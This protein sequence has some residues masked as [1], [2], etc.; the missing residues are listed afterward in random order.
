MYLEKI[1]KL[2]PVPKDPVYTGDPA[3]IKKLEDTLN[4]KLPT[5]YYE[6]TKTYG[7]GYFGGHFIVYNPFIEYE[8]LNL[9]F[10]LK[11][12]R[13]CYECA[14]KSWNM[15]LPG[16]DI[17]GADALLALYEA[18]RNENGKFYSCG[19]EFD[20]IGHP[21]SFFPE[22][23]GLFPCCEYN[24][25]YTIYW[26]TGEE[27]WTIVVYSNDCYSEFDMSLTEFIYKLISK[28]V[29]LPTL[30][31]IFTLKGLMFEKYTEI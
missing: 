9:L 5:D 30:Y 10:M 25:E 26:K 20:N 18:R 28:E 22:K 2:I 24:G 21:F 27:K 7:A 31:N 16:I 1:T 11:E 3:Q 29:N 4:I 12:N 23:E 17:K 8:P 19:D 13:Y 14:K 6:L 15:E